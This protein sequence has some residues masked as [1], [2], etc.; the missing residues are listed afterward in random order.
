[1]CSNINWAR[2]RQCNQCQ[3]EKPGTQKEERYGKGGGFRELQDPKDR[4]KESET[5]Y[6]LSD[7][8]SPAVF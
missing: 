4:R 8:P 6:Y 2:R 1:M 3:H 7:S 5:K